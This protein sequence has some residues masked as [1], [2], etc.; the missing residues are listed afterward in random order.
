MVSCGYPSWEFLIKHCITS[1]KVSGSINR[2]AYPGQAGDGAAV[3]VGGPP[4]RNCGGGAGRQGILST[5]YGICV[6]SGAFDNLV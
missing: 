6:D 1:W 4:T 2:E 3:K 5:L